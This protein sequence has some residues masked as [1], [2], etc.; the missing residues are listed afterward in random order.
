VPLLTPLELH[1]ARTPEE[2][3]EKQR[4]FIQKHFALTPRVAPANPPALLDGGALRVK[5]ECGN[6]AVVD[7]DARL[8]CCFQC[9][10]VYE[11]IDIPEDY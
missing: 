11:Q 6:Y 5:C 7:P 2:Y 1:G 3:R 8:A 4:Q 10:L 9:G